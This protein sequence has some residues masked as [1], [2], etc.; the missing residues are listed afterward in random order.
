MIFLCQLHLYLEDGD[1]LSLQETS[2][3]HLH[4]YRHLL[5]QSSK[6]ISDCMG[7]LKMAYL[8]FGKGGRGNGVVM[9]AFAHGK[10]D[11][12]NNLLAS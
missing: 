7:S 9:H 1:F 3:E 12:D 6:F 2:L 8:R 5:S 11:N 10:G 4:E